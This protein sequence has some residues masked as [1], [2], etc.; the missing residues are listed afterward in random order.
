MVDELWKSSAVLTRVLWKVLPK[1]FV[2]KTLLLKVGVGFAPEL[3]HAG[4]GQPK[5]QQ[6]EQR[7]KET[8]RRAGK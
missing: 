2:F 8:Y 6:V 5:K 1:R 4:I 3:C 7:Y